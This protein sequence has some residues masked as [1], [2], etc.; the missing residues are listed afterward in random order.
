MLLVSIVRARTES[1]L[2]AALEY[3]R[4]SLRSEAVREIRRLAEGT[5]IMPAY[6]AALGYMYLAY[7]DTLIARALGGITRAPYRAG[8]YYPAAECCAALE[9]IRSAWLHFVHSVPVPIEPYAK[10]WAGSIRY[11]WP[12]RVPDSTVHLLQ[13]MRQYLM[14]LAHTLSVS[15]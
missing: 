12:C 2:Q 15:Q 13:S 7:I 11:E 9:G 5:D 6:H 3:F 1:D 8:Y 14:T 10:A 4:A